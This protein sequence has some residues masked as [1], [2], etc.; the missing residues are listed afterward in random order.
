MKH[1]ATS[2]RPASASTSRALTVCGRYHTYLLSE[3]AEKE[4][5]RARRESQARYIQIPDTNDP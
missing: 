2:A 1:G 5:E 4:A 3:R